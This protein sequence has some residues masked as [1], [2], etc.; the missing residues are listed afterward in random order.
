MNVLPVIHTERDKAAGELAQAA[1]EQ[2]G[3]KTTRVSLGSDDGSSALLPVVEAGVAGEMPV[4]AWV[5]STGALDIEAHHRDRAAVARHFV[6]LPFEGGQEQGRLL[7]LLDGPSSSA[8]DLP[9]A[10]IVTLDELLRREF[11]SDAF[12]A[13]FSFSRT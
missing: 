12:C 7:I 6:G 2:L 3:F 11:D 5:V 4:Q 1:L 9:N 8:P 10:A 13:R